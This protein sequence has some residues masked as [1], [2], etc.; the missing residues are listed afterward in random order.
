ML[1]LAT[2]VVVI[3]LI[4]VLLSSGGTSSS[5]ASAARS[6]GS[7]GAGATIAD[8]SGA[9]AD[10]SAAVAPFKRVPAGPPTDQRR[11][12]LIKTIS[13]HISPKSVAASDTGL[14][15]AQ[16]MMYTHTVTVYN[17]AGS[18]VKTIPDTVNMASFG[19][20]G[21]PGITHGA[22]VEAAFTPDARHVYVSNYSMYGTGFGPEGNDDCT[23]ASAEAAGDTNSYVYR[24]NTSTLAIDQVIQVGLVPK[25]L[26]V[27]P[28]G[29]YLLVSNWCSYDLSVVN[30]AEG[31]QVA[32]LPMG[33][34][35]RGLAISP[36]SQTAYV[37]I[38]GGDT[39]VKVNL[40]NLTEEGSFAVGENPRHLVID[41]TGHF[42]YASLNGPGDVVKINL[43]TD[44][45]VGETHT[46][47][48]CRSL[49]IS[50]DGR[51]LYVVNYSS[52]TITKLRA[53]DLSVLQ[54]V[55]TGVHPIGI[56]YDAST[57]DIWVAVYS[58]QI[59]VFA[60]RA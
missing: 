9:R 38:M 47:D 31:K 25:F 44:L 1:G 37:A 52:D 46:G 6:D 15:F 4:V 16:N 12:A 26:A 20:P 17:S 50:A 45:V 35:P 60:E 53:S 41:P 23:P 51:S 29:K 39:V 22:P 56:T 30:I 2:L 8:R 5:T 21:H 33:A 40:A 48:D 42:L 59:L 28:N 32:R 57:G 54:T 3:G 49:A 58:G 11:L 19:F 43:A 10:K 14:V 27:T 24:L 13:G 34:Y 7:Q 55:P 18:L 36:N